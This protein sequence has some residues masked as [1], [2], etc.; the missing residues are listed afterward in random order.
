MM[1]D[2]IYGT[3]PENLGLVDIDPTEMMFW[4]YCPIKTPGMSYAVV[5]S[6]LMQFAPLI[7]KVKADCADEWQ[8][9][10]VY[11]TAK[12]L[13]VKPETPGNRPGW[14]SDGFMTDDLNYIWSDRNP[15][16]FFH[17][18]SRHAFSADHVHSLDEMNALCEPDSSKHFR[19]AAKHLM[20]L[21]QRV[22]HKVDTNITAGMRTFVKISVSK[23][24]YALKGNSINHA[25]PI[26]EV[27]QERG[28]ERNCPTGRK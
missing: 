10:Y 18:G 5:P 8:D 20:K 2:K 3:Q 21:D 19:Y 6:N 16:V 17:D 7:E 15:T 24:V 9:R 22:L 25:L 11:I 1:T 12:T 14:H 13:Y 23:D 4:M 27:Y 28:A 26:A